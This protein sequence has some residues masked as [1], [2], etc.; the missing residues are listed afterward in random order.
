MNKYQFEKLRQ[1]MALPTGRHAVYYFNVYSHLLGKTVLPT[2][3][4]FLQS[5]CRSFQRNQAIYIDTLIFSL[6]RGTHSY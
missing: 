4:K 6:L 5:L 1:K 3:A 2:L